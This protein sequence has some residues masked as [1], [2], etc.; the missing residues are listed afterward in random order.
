MDNY[1]TDIAQTTFVK[2]VSYSYD[3]RYSLKTYDDG[4][5][6]A[7]YE[8]DALLRKTSETVNYGPFSLN[9]AYTYFANG[10]KKTFTG[11][12]GVTTTYGYDSNNQLS[13]IQT[14]SGAITYNSYRWTSPAHSS[15]SRWFF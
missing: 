11:P 1:Y 5:T 3:A 4:L 10:K 12:D 6:S 8:Y 2:S 14:P 9:Y 15:R 7:S 13:S